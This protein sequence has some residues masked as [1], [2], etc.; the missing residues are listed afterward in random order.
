MPHHRDIL[1][2]AI[3]CLLAGAAGGVARGDV[4]VDESFTGPTAAAPMRVGGSF[5]PCLTASTDT[6]QD[7]VPGCRA[8]QPSIP[9]GGD[10]DGGGALR[11]TDNAQNRSGFAIHH[12]VLPFTYGVRFT[13]TAFA[14][15][16]ERFRDFGAADGISVFFIDGDERTDRPGAFGG[17]L[18]Y[19]QKSTVFAD[20]APD[21]PGIPGGVFGVGLDEFGNFA[22]D[23]EGRGYGCARRTDFDLHPNFISLRGPGEPGSDWLRGYCLEKRV[24][25]SGAL[26]APDAK[27]R[28]GIGHTFRIDVDPL[29]QPDGTPNPHAR[30][31]VEADMDN[32]GAFE[33]VLDAPLEAHPPDTF[34]FGFAASTGDGTNIHEI[35]ALR[36]ET[37]AHLPRWTL[38]KTHQPTPMVA[39]TTGRLRLRAGLDPDGGVAYAPVTLT[40]RLPPGLTVA[41]TPHGGA[42]DCAETVVGTDEVRCSHAAS[43]EHP[44]RPGTRLPE[45]VVDVHVAPDADDHLV[46]RAELTGSELLEPVGAED[47]IDVRRDVDLGI[48]KV[49]DPTRVVP[50]GGTRFMLVATNRGPGDARDVVVEDRLPATLVPVAAQ[51]SAGRC[52]V[53][54]VVVRCALGTVAAEASAQV[55]VDATATPAAPAGPATDVATVTSSDPDTDPGDDRAAATV[56][57]VGAPTPGGPTPGGPVAGADTGLTVT[58]RASP[59]RVRIGDPVTY[60]IRVHNGGEAT[61]HDVRIVDTM[62]LPD[63]VRAAGASCDAPADTGAVTCRLGDLGPGRTATVTARATFRRAG[64]AANA[65]AVAPSDAPLARATVAVRGGAALA[66][67]KTVDRRRVRVGARLRFRV[68]VRSLGPEP[69]ERV[70]VCDRLPHA[71]ERVSGGR[72]VCWTLAG[73]VPGARR[74]FTVR[75]VA[76]APTSGPVRN[77]ATAG[78]ANA[79]TVHAARSVAVRPAP[80]PSG[81]G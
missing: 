49:A 76:I 12:H 60:T 61:A 39:G 46:N 68:V 50:G 19:A 37:I 58:K 36:V 72:R 45:L 41:R 28:E 42:W 33:E 54:L 71:L 32:D 25:A 7:N 10:P 38:V 48:S 69:A 75:A 57:V 62:S 5:T 3:A 70:R 73:L 14:Y 1:A 22:N 21:L 59:T 8:N 29:G 43:L 13:F 66:I 44:L 6:H 2:L 34:E 74:A 20:T 26:D 55:V 77:V 9:P 65:V 35:R 40:D 78:A 51:S 63:T 18:G 79:A 17:S 15:N 67:A 4:L 80:E 53:A 30:V 11:L 64:Q 24:E 56:E 16:G 47:P 52:A 23:F 27:S 81:L 31:R